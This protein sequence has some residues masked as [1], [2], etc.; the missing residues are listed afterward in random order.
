MPVTRVR[1]RFAECFVLAPIDQLY[2]LYH[3]HA[4]LMWESL[5][6]TAVD[7][8]YVRWREPQND[9]VR[10]RPSWMIALVFAVSDIAELE[11][12][13]RKGKEHD[14]TEKQVGIESQNGFSLVH[15]NKAELT[16]ENLECNKWNHLK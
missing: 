16:I 8:C 1:R 3:P 2:H 14:K 15:L 12:V 4:L 6:Q 5:V 7:G 13:P 10:N 11:S 9:D